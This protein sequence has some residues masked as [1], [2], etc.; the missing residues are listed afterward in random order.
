MGTISAGRLNRLLR[1][2]KKSGSKHPSGQPVDAWELHK[3]K[4]GN[5]K[6]KSGSAATRENGGVPNEAVPVSIRV[7]YD[8]TI[9]TD[10]RVVDPEGTIFSIGTISHDHA[11]RE[12]TDLVCTV[13]GNNG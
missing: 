4:Y 8:R 10:M 11:D 7:R 2:E 3:E 12:W 5:I 6:S 1:I 9:T 13:G